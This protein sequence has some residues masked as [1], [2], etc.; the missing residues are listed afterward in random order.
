MSRNACAGTAMH[1]VSPHRQASMTGA[2]IHGILL[3]A[4][5]I[6]AVEPSDGYTCVPPEGGCPDGNKSE[7]FFLN[8]SA[9]DCYGL[10]TSGCDGQGFDSIVSCKISC[11]GK[12]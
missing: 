11:L 12:G 9:H 6:A 3:A 1:R 4:F 2:T 7:R 5:M 10:H 8:R